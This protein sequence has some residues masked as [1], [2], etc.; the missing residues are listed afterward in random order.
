MADIAQVVLVHDE[1]V[2]SAAPW[3][4]RQLVESHPG[5]PLGGP[6]R[7]RAVP[8]THAGKFQAKTLAARIPKRAWQRL[9][10]GSGAKGRRYYDWAQVEV[11]GPAGRLGQWCLLVRHNRRTGELAFYRC[12]SPRP[13][14]MSELVRVAGRRWT[15]EETFQASKGLTGVAST[16]SAAGP[17]GTAGS[18]SQC[19][20]TPS[21]PS[22]Q[23]PNAATDPPQ[24]A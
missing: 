1:V 24:T 23:P 15:V 18:P 7:F 11:H 5:L 6:A 9:S 19:S 4:A 12:F 10:A 20:P 21:S 17:A 2:P 16:K 13:V 8:F 22:P 14:P 3:A